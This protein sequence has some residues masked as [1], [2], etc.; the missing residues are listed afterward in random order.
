MMVGSM[1]RGAALVMLVGALSLGALP[2]QAA[3]ADGAE[4]VIAAN[5]ALGKVAQADPA[6]AKAL[7]DDIQMALLKPPGQQKQPLTRGVSPL[8]SGDRMMLED[9]PALAR[10]YIHDA[11]AALSLLRRVKEAGG[12]S[13]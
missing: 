1:R 8:D 6:K 5:P 11:S 13:K 10:L 9:N 4:T 7:A 12:G 3:R 2:W